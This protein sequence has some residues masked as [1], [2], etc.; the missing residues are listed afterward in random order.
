[1]N[2]PSDALSLPEI[3]ALDASNERSVYLSAAVNPI[4]RPR[5]RMNT[6]SGPTGSRVS[7][8]HYGI[9][10]TGRGK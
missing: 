1:M 2:Y 5:I 9:V 6:A 7:T 3:S 10:P 4:C 8:R